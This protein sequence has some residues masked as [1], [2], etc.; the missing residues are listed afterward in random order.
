MCESKD[1]DFCERVLWSDESKFNLFGT[2]RRVMVWR[3]PKE[4]FQPAWTVPTVKH[5]GANVKIWGC[6]AWNGVRNLVFIDGNMTGYMYKDILENDLF[7]SALKLNL[8]KNIVFQH[9]NNPKHTV[10]IIKN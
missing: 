1:M 5:G 9:D 4:E 8:G 2:D 3:A 6:L 7:Q 10:H